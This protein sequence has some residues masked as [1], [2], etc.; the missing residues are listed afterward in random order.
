M[1]DLV[2]APV[3]AQTARRAFRVSAFRMFRMFRI[4]R[5]RTA[6]VVCSGLSFIALWI[7]GRGRLDPD[8]GTFVSRSAH[9]GTN[10]THQL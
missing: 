1:G 2:L 10:R 3:S 8:L 7:P 5:I 9:S 6:T 4:R